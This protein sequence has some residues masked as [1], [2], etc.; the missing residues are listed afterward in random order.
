[1]SPTSSSTAQPPRTG[2]KPGQAK[3]RAPGRSYLW[4]ALIGVVIVG[5][6]AIAAIVSTGS[7]DSSTTTA[8]FEA[9]PS[10]AAGDALPAFDSAV[11]PDPAVGKTIPT[12][13]G[14]D[15]H[16]LPMTVKGDGKPK[17][18]VFLAHWCPHCQREVPVL[19]DWLA[20]HATQKAETVSV[21]TSI[22]KTLPNYPPSDWLF[23][24]NWSVPVLVDGNEASARAYGLT[25]FPYFVVVGADGTVRQ[26]TS[27]EL[28]TE[29]IAA[30][31]ATAEK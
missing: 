5:G 2:G 25:S 24:E 6:L 19:R 21:T 13:S 17:V 16:G 31:Y 8:A 22:N 29:Q 9:T 20:D 15:L 11:S 23:K 10:T 3:G 30:L 18:V 28:S 1:M 12:L 4:L 27:G 26:R 14:T 7:K